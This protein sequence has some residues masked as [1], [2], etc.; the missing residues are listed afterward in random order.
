MKMAQSSD[1]YLFP[2]AFLFNSFR[3]NMLERKKKQTFESVINPVVYYRFVDD[4]FA[5]LS[6]KE[7]CS[8]LLTILNS[9]QS[10]L[11]FTFEKESHNFLSFSNVLVKK[12]C[13]EKVKKSDFSKLNL[14]LYSL[15][16]TFTSK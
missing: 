10:Y 3:D 14:R 4:A 6:N 11:C 8:K 12:V 15:T 2:E 5:V 13:S 1:L 9:S 7:E 16:Q